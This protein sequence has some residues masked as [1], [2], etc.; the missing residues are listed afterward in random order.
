MNAI[1]TAN[2]I[3]SPHQKRFPP[4]S[5]DF[6][7]L[8]LFNCRPAQPHVIRLESRGAWHILGHIGHT[9]HDS[10][11]ASRMRVSDKMTIRYLS[12]MS[13]GGEQCTPR[14]SQNLLF[15]APGKCATTDL[16][17]TRHTLHQRHFSIGTLR[18]GR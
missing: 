3:L 4:T 5:G 14:G 1:Q 10:G 12:E 7:K 15:A 8:K 18:V 11:Q 9:I 13:C 16:R 6:A 2:R 17:C